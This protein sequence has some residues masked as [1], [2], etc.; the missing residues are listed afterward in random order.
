MVLTTITI[1]RAGISAAALALI[2]GQQRVNAP[3]EDV[4]PTVILISTP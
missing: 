4:L 3:S 1:R 2:A